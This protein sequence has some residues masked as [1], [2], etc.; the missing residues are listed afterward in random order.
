MLARQTLEVGPDGS[1]NCR[2]PI[3]VDGCRRTASRL[4]DARCEP[5][6]NTASP[7]GASLGQK[8]QSRQMPIVEPPKPTVEA[9]KGKKR[10]FPPSRRRREIHA[11]NAGI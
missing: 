11:T 2:K 6:G 3:V 7:L 4:H 10:T 8:G 5:D 1:L 9:R